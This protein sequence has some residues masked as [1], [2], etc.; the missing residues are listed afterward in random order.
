MKR[1]RRLVGIVTINI[2]LLV[3]LLELAGFILSFVLPG[4]QE[5][6]ARFSRADYERFLAKAYDPV[7]G[8][9][10]RPNSRRIAPN[11]LGEEITYTYDDHGARVTPDGE[12]GGPTIVTFGDSY[13]Q[14]DEVPDTQS[15]P[16]HLGELL[17]TKVYNYGTAGYGPV[18]MYLKMV[19]TLDRYP[20]TDAAVLTLITIDLRRMLNAYRPAIYGTSH[21]LYGFKPFMQGEVVQSNPNGPMPAPFEEFV[22]MARRALA[23]DYWSRAQF[24]FPYIVGIYQLLVSNQTRHGIAS[25]FSRPEWQDPEIVANLFA[26]FD[27]IFAAAEARG[28]QPFIALV[29][30]F[31]SHREAVDAFYQDLPDALRD[32]F[33]LVD[34]DDIDWDRYTL[35]PEACHPSPYGYAMIAEKIAAALRA[36]M[37][38]L[39]AHSAGKV[40]LDRTDSPQQHTAAE[41]K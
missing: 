34:G 9:D 17:D 39:A 29:P 1:L 5:V 33:I 31:T 19:E 24:S 30:E 7:T 13:T 40:S 27:M 38:S 16:Y 3:V 26:L 12:S 23:D 20:D 35:V 21:I 8:W 22:S 11:C 4:P 15:Y 14:G 28:V 2:L 36:R 6:V 18:Q 41:V 10:N 25:A 37:P 32:R